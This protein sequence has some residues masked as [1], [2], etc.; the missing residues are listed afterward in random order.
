MS[1]SILLL[2]QVLYVEL[3]YDQGAFLNRVLGQGTMFIFI[4]FY[5]LQLNV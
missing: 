1:A 4:Y 5:V 3:Y 2:L